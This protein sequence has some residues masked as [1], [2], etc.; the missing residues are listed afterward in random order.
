MSLRTTSR[1]AARRLATQ[2]NLVL[3]EVAMLADGADPH[4]SQSQIETMLHAV[5]DAHLTKLDRVAFAAKSS[6]EFDLKQARA[7]DRRAYWAYALLDAQGVTA[8]V[9]AEDRRRM[10]EDGMSEID[11]EAVQNHLALLRVNELVPT[12]HHILRHMIEGVEAVPTAMNLA[13]AQ[14]TC[15]RGMKLALAECDRRY[16]G[17]R[18]EDEGLVDRLQTG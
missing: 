8:V 3:D 11:I 7:D 13:V 16:G 15:L 2:L 9:R 5:V 18:I 1:L 4:L 6:L 10:A 17:V 12:K 14:G